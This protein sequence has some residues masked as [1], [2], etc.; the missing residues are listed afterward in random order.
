[1]MWTG[2]APT[3]FIHQ[4]QTVDG[5]RGGCNVEVVVKRHDPSRCLCTAFSLFLRP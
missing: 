3:A 1:M 2:G 4:G 5:E